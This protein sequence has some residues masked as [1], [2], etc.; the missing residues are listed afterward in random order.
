MSKQFER[1]DRYLVIKRSDLEEVQDGFTQDAIDTFN[2]ICQAVMISR[3]ERGKPILNCVVVESDWPE[4][5]PTWKAIE[6]RFTN[7]H[8]L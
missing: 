1:E 7:N 4:Y 8:P 2:E 5:E 3:D 6:E